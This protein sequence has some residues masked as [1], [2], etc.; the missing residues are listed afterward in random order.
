MKAS[1]AGGLLLLLWITGAASAAVPEP[2]GAPAETPPSEAVPSTSPTPSPTP[3]SRVTRQ[4]QNRH[5]QLPSYAR[6]G[7]DAFAD[8]PDIPAF[9]EEVEVF[10]RAT[11]TEALTAKMRWWMSDFEPMNGR[12]GGS[13]FQAPTLADMRDHRP[14]PAQALNFQPLLGWLIGKIKPSK[15]DDDKR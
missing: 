3:V 1:V 10:G 8:A 2:P 7:V 13:S 12:S 14:S 6:Y 9:S 5:L 4:L 11:D 15:N